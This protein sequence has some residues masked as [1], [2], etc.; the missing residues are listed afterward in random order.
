MYSELMLSILACLAE[1]ESHSISS[2][3]KWAIRCRFADGTYLQAIAPY[4]GTER[5]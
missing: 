2:N 1:D 3:M 5:K 4:M